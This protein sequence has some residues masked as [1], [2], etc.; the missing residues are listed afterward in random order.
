MIAYWDGFCVLGEHL[1]QN[2][3]FSEPTRT[4]SKRIEH[5]YCIS[6]PSIISERLG[7]LPRGYWSKYFCSGKKKK[8][9]NGINPLC[10]IS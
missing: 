7:L 4:M 1:Y 9:K 2:I 3:G 10:G 5:N 8:S 6:R